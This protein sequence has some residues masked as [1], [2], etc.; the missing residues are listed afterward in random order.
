M[1][2]N[3]LVDFGIVMHDENIYVLKATVDVGYMLIFNEWLH[4]SDTGEF[5]YIVFTTWVGVCCLTFSY[6]Y[7]YI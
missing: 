5:Q 1:I 2:M 7:I 6:K 4:N 3:Y